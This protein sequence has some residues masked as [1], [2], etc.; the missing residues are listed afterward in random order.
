MS[1]TVFKPYTLKDLREDANCRISIGEY[2]ECLL[3]FFYL[4]ESAIG[5]FVCSV[6]NMG[7]ND[8]LTYTIDKLLGKFMYRFLFCY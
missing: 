6:A 7:G 1:N 3:E 2:G 8:S 5:D 4:N